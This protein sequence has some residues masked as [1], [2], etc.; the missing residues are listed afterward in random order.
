MSRRAVAGL[1][2]L[3]LIA[4]GA[5]L[6]LRE[7][8]PFVRFSPGPTVNVLGQNG[9]KKIITVTGRKTYED[10]GAL[11]LVTVYVTGPKD[12]Q[13]LAETLVAWADPDVAVLPHDSVYRAN[14]TNKSSRQESAAEMTSSQ[15][16]ATA[17]AL[18]ALGIKYRSDLAVALVDKKGA[19]AGL[20]KPGDLLRSVDGK[21]AADDAAFIAAIKPLAP[22][23]KVRIGINRGGEDREVTITTR[24][25]PDDK[26]K[27]RIN[28]SITKKLTFP[29]KVDI[30]LDDNIG[31]PSAG[32]MF[33]LSIYD[34]LTPGSLT[35]G[36]VIAGSGEISPDGVV[37]PIGGIGQKIVAAQRDGAELFLVAQENCAEAAEA[38][39]DKDKIRLVKVHKLKDAIDDLEAWRANPKAE[40]PGCGR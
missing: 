16:S 13:S 37:G 40:L 4:V 2:A 39:Y 24:P 9:D 19:S 38:H 27:S 33:A 34:L 29:F 23:T 20:L 22:G 36:K 5:F 35:G 30:N 8:S 6:G 25:A 14:E 17:A 15:D 11:R 18:G 10:D 7:P 32:M 31:G 28:I 1:L 21:A 26:T 3:G 12:E